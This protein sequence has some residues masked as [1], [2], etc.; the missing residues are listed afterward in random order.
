MTQSSG[1]DRVPEATAQ[2]IFLAIQQLA[3]RQ[4]RTQ[5]QLDQLQQTVEAN[6]RQTALNTE[7]MTELRA[8]VLELRNI[9]ADF[10]HAQT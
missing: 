2:T 8:S 3:E 10:I 7:G 6:S 9:L 1:S 4:E 5:I